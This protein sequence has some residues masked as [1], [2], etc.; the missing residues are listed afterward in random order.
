MRTAWRRA[1]RTASPRPPTHCAKTATAE[2]T[3]RCVA[4]GSPRHF[5]YGSRWKVVSTRVP[6][7][8]LGRRR[9]AAAREV[10]RAP[11]GCRGLAVRAAA[12]ACLGV[13]VVAVAV[14]PGL[15]LRDPRARLRGRQ[16]GRRV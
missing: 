3:N 14:A 1:L 11:A 4:G 13:R 2:G 7:G 12:D 16:A 15:A 5:G 9:M 6:C 8:R 10:G